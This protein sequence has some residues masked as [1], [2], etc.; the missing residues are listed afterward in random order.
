MQVLELKTRRWTRD[1]YYR[2][3][4]MGFF[5][6]QRVELLEGE[7]IE[8]SPQL[9][10][11]A[12]AIGLAELALR[13]VFG[14]A[15]WVRTQLPLHVGTSSAPEPDLAV[16]KGAPRDFN[17]HP[18]TALLV[19]EVSESTLAYDRTR[20]A[21][22]YARAGIADYWI[23]NLAERCLEVYREP[24]ADTAQSY[25]FGYGAFVSRAAGDSVAPLHL[26]GARIAVADLL[27]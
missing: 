4:E 15:C 26:P 13:G 22:L 21:S 8:M 10:R 9:S 6:D 24:R 27:P 2:M 17:E 16:V 20:K 18:A 14:L 12:V 25:G 19:V 5:Q 7:V 11:H 1:E 3:G 23:V